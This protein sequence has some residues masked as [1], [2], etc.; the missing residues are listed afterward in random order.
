MLY[1]RS[2]FIDWLRK[3]KD[4]DI[5]PL[6]DDRYR[7]GGI[8]IKNGVMKFYMGTDPQD[9]IDYEEIYIAC[10]KLMIVGLPGNSDL[11][12]IE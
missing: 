11:K 8:L 10:T 3:V 9:E 2:S 4:C 7:S 5:I 12:R 1:K 6:D